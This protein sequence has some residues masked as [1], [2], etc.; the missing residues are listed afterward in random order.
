MKVFAI[1]PV[2]RFEH[3]KTRLSSI[4]NKDERVI[5]SSLLLEDTLEVLS[6]TSSLYK[7]VVVSEDE[8]AEQIATKYAAIFLREEREKGVNY[9]VELA[10]IYCIKHF[11][12]LTIVI[13]FDLPLLDAL[14]INKAIELSENEGRCVVIC[15]SIRYDGT[16]LLL[17]KPPSVMVTFYDKDSYNMHVRVARK[18]GIYVKNINSEDVMR[19][20]DTPEDALYLIKHHHSLPARSLKF[21]KS[22]L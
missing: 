22:R 19:D 2:K 18:L 6:S 21:I 20:L 10:N 1:V 8:R 15:P 4:L 16:N 11:A 5:L 14:D 17:R 9:A 7:V 12:D 3:S 13:P